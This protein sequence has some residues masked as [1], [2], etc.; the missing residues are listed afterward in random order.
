TGPDADATL[1]TSGGALG[2]PASG[3]LTNTTG[4]VADLAL[5]ENKAV[6]LV[7]LTLS[8]DGK[9]TGTTIA[10]TA[11][12]TLAF[13]DLIYLAAADSRWELAD[14]DAASTAGDVVLG[15]C[16][17]AAA[18]DGDATNVLLYGKV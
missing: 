12:T 16:V 18:A 5:A 2:T 4:Y 14:A 3:T 11:G 8:A 10:G 9:Y 1:L 7:G 17:L 6:K 15:I 13:G